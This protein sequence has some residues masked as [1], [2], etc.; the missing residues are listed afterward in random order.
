MRRVIGIV[1]LA[2]ALVVGNFA[3]TSANASDNGGNDDVIRLVAK[4][5]VDEYIDLA[6]KGKPNAGDHT[7]FS[8]DV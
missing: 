1:L 4:A 2:V 7:V 5:V 8:D 6:P 3:L